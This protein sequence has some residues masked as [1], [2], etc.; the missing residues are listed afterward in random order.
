MTILSGS[1]IRRYIPKA[2]VGMII[3]I[4]YEKEKSRLRLA[5]NPTTKR[6]EIKQ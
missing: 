6:K 2:I 5:Q 1:R 3:A 4:N